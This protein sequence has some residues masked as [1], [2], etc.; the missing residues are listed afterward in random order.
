MASK[1]TGHYDL[2][3]WFYAICLLLL[4]FFI[5]FLTHKIET[6]TPS[7]PPPPQCPMLFHPIPSDNQDVIV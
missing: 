4:V 3:I 7:S 1:R 6:S 2:D 5:V